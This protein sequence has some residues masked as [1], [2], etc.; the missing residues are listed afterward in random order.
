MKGRTLQLVFDEQL[1]VASTPAG[2]AFLVETDDLDGDKRSIAGTGTATV[3]TRT[4]AVE[5]DE[6]EEPVGPDDLVSVSYTVPTSNPL[7]NDFGADV[8]AFERFRV[9]TVLDGI[10]PAFVDG[11][12]MQTSSSPAASKVIIYFDEPLDTTSVPVAANFSLLLVGGNIATI[13]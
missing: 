1:N 6:N 11:E 7:E 9:E 4:V 13:S 8:L 12:A 10:P 3:S 2:S 5:L